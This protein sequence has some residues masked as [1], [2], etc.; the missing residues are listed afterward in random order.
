MYK[1]FDELKEALRGT[2]SSP[3]VDSLSSVLSPSTQKMLCRKDCGDVAQIIMC[4]ISLI[5]A[6]SM[7]T[8]DE[9]V[10]SRL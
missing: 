5:D 4:S 10:R 1:S 9:L 6:G 3:V 8:M 2:L 7:K